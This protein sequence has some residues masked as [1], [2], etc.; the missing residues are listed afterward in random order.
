M[1][2]AAEQI[3]ALYHFTD[4]RNLPSIRNTGGLY[5]TERLA[6]MGI[7]GFHPGGNEQSLESDMRFGMDKFVHLCLKSEHPMEYL[8]R[9]DGRIE[10]TA[11][12]SIN[13]GILTTPGVLYSAGVSNKAGMVHLPVAEAHDLIDCEVL[14]TKTDWKQPEIRERLL[15]AKKCEILIPD[16]I[17]LAYIRSFPNG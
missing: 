4:Q 8:A 5:S 6:L 3:R 15:A 10:S 16:H 7:G 12:L 2:T 14:Y 9:R 11:W 1:A 13:L 17:P